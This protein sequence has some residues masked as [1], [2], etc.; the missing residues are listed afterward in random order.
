MT[1]PPSSHRAAEPRVAGLLTHAL[2]LALAIVAL[3]ISLH[4][5]LTHRAVSRAVE[6]AAMRELEGLGARAAMELAGPLER[7]D[8]GEIRRVVERMM[9][10][11]LLSSL[12]ILD[13]RGDATLRR[14]RQDGADERRRE[15]AISAPSEPLR[16]AVRVRSGDEPLGWTCRTPVWSSGSP[17]RLL[18]FIVVAGDDGSVRRAQAAVPSAA[19]TAGA[20]SV[21]LASPLAAL[22]AARLVRPIRRVAQAAEA[23]ERGEDPGPLSSGGPRETRR[24]ASSFNRMSGSLRAALGDLEAAKA[25]L[26]RKVEERTEQLATINAMLEDQ[27]RAKNEFLRSVTHDLGAPLRNIAGMAE[28]VLDENA[29]ALPEEARRRLE[30]ITANVRIESDMLAELLELSRTVERAERVETIEVEGVARELSASLGDDLRRRRIELRIEPGLPTLRVDRTDLWMLLQ[31]LTENAIKY[32]GD[33]PTRR[34]TIGPLA[35]GLGAGFAISDTGPGIPEAER[36][37]VFRVF[38]RASTGRSESGRGVGL[39]VVRSIVERWSGNVTLECPPA[40]GSRFEVRVPASRRC[41]PPTPPVSP[42]SR[43][44]TGGTRRAA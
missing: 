36:G 8:E 26:E 4:A 14:I 43:D 40:G 5:G 37:R 23:L 9:T 1:A 6:D 3:T 25:N 19:L 11:Q 15:L 13:H 42:E 34:V 41:D 24:L 21:L 28:L 39:A 18:G 12:T 30:R 29:G 17:E 10:G 32:M 38:E 20:L 35:A 7:W 33:S 22:G 16:R 27:V 44:A 2:L 31:N